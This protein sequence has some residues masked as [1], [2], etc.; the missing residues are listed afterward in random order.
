MV[1]I[2]LA[3]ACSFLQAFTG[4]GVERFVMM[5]GRVTLAGQILGVRGLEGK[6]ACAHACKQ[7]K[8]GPC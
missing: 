7:V 3:A 4:I 2:G 5:T 8:V 6:L 1:Q